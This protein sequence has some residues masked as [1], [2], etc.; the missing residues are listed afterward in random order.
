M[1]II[2]LT[3]P[4]EQGNKI[5]TPRFPVKVRISKGVKKERGFPVDLNDCFNVQTIGE[6]G[7]IKRILQRAYGQELRPKEIVF[8]FCG[9]TPDEV[10]DPSFKEWSGTGLVKEC[11]G[12]EIIKRQIKKQ[13]GYISYTSEPIACPYPF[14]QSEKPCPDC[15]REGTIFLELPVLEQAGFYVRAKITIGGIYNIKSIY[16][17]LQSFY[18]QFG[19]LLKSEVQIPIT[20]GR[21]PFLMRRSQTPI[22]VPNFKDSGEKDTK[23]KAVQVRSGTLRDSSY[24]EVNIAP[25]PAYV[26]MIEYHRLQI[27]NQLVGTK[28]TTQLKP[29]EIIKALPGNSHIIDVPVEEA[30]EKIFAERIA[31]SIKEAAAGN[32]QLMSQYYNKD[33]IAEVATNLLHRPIQNSADLRSDAECALVCEGI[34]RLMKMEEF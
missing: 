21:I 2:G 26:K 15:R 24:W 3:T 5:C 10:F 17:S 34:V 9:E 12:R 1:P 19:S 7:A 13:D 11:N 8:Y 6:A 22:K 30:P 18:S 20:G 31:I 29:A 28:L 27:Q 4:D 23:G 16:S 32:Q 33:K 14:G 25:H